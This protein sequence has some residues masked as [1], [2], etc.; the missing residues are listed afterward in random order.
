M[1]QDFSE[2]ITEFLKRGRRGLKYSVCKKFLQSRVGKKWDDVWS[3]IS[4]ISGKDYNIHL[5]RD[6]IKNLVTID[7]LMLDDKVCYCAYGLIANIEELSYIR[8][9]YYVHPSTKIL[10]VT[11]CKSQRKLREEAWTNKQLELTKTHRKID[12]KV[13]D[14]INDVWFETIE[15]KYDYWVDDV[16]KITHRTVSKKEKKLLGLD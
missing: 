13:Y 16:Y 15:V 4:D 12:G 2:V 6:V 14:K 11:A 8:P 3:E 9:I 1:R 10:M 7:T 5:T